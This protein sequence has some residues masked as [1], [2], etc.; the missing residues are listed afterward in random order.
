MCSTELTSHWMRPFG[1]LQRSRP[2]LK[3]ERPYPGNYRRLSDLG[4]SDYYGPSATLSTHPGVDFPTPE[5]SAEFR[6]PKHREDFDGIF[7]PK[8]VGLDVRLER[9]RGT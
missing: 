1:E 4:A 2:S 6:S 8:A 3:P 9:G 7:Q 5:E